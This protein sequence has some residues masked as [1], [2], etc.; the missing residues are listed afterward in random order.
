[1]GVQ[2]PKSR[3]RRHMDVCEPASLTA[4][5]PQQGEIPE[6]RISGFLGGIW[7]THWQIQTVGILIY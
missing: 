1:M 2:G 7:I 3:V 5:V 4:G 6:G